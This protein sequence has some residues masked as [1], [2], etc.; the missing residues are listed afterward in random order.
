MMRIFDI[1]FDHSAEFK[2][3][4]ENVESFSQ[5]GKYTIM[6]STTILRFWLD[7]QTKLLATPQHRIKCCY[8]VF[9]QHKSKHQSNQPGL[10]DRTRNGEKKP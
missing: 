4:W 10:E 6:P 9:Q 8:N 5:I 7:V 1:L 3:T 2:S